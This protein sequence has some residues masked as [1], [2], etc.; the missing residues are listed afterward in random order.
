L[1]I[2]SFHWYDDS[3]RATGEGE[4]KN[5]TARSLD[6]LKATMEL[7]DKNGGYLTSGSAMIDER[8]LPP[9]H[10]SLFKISAKS[11]PKMHQ[12]SVDFSVGG[13]RLRTFYAEAD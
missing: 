12:A 5:L 1:E 6:K 9:E 8:S 10:M 13:E 4:V 7:Y 3:G 11:N 2:V